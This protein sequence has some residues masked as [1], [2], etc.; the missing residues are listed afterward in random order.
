M[1]YL[2][3][4]K[5]KGTTDRNRCRIKQGGGGAQYGAQ[6]KHSKGKGGGG[7]QHKHRCQGI[8]K[9]GCFAEERVFSAMDSYSLVSPRPPAVLVLP[10]CCARS[11]GGVLFRVLCMV[12]E[13][14]AVCVVSMAR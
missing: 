6:Y 12:S 9:W 7:G 5:E 13:V 3:E 4:H 14:C 2:I 10:P 1:A 8:H 11:A